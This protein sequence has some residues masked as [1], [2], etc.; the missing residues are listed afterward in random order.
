MNTVQMPRLH[1]HDFKMTTGKA[2]YA[3]KALVNKKGK[4]LTF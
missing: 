3:L 1:Y 2:L 4:I